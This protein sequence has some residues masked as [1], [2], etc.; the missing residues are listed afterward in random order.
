MFLC[1]VDS[2]IPREESR[3]QQDDNSI[4]MVEN[5]DMIMQQ[6]QADTDK[7]TEGAVTDESED[8]VNNYYY[9]VC[10]CKGEK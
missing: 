5:L 9:P 7:L 1:Q 3:L 6:L 2:E 10:M 8:E 4:N